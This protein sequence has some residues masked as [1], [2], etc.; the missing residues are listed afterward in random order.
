MVGR[1]EHVTIAAWRHPFPHQWLP[2]S[3]SDDTSGP[4]L[5]PRHISGQRQGSP[6][7]AVRE[8]DTKADSADSHRQR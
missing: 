2:S 8:V 7:D 5:P 4:N 6:H 1:Q 3:Q